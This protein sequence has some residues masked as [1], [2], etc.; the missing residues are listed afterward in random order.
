[1]IERRVLVD[2]VSDYNW[3]EVMGLVICFKLYVVIL[4]SQFKPQWLNH[5]IESHNYNLRISP[6]CSKNLI[7]LLRIVFAYNFLSFS[8]VI[9]VAFPR[10]FKPTKSN[11]PRALIID[12]IKDRGLSSLLNTLNYT[13]N[14]RRSLAWNVGDPLIS[15]IIYPVQSLKTRTFFVQKRFRIFWNVQNYFLSEICVEKRNHSR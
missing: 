4:R 13:Q 15:W 9:F 7:F 1:V 8:L 11:W 2:D 3:P 6:N 5:K 14:P 10:K 12:L